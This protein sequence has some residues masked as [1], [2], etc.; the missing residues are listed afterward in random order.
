MIN[1]INFSE[2][3][4]SLSIIYNK[5]SNFENNNANIL[6]KKRNLWLLHDINDRYLNFAIDFIWNLVINKNLIHFK[7]KCT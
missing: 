6:I 2:I 5:Y 4:I 3:V 7:K 1:Q